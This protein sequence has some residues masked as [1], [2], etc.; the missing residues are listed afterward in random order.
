MESSEL[1]QLIRLLDNPSALSEKIR[2]LKSKEIDDESVE[3][4]IVMYDLYNGN[5]SAIKQELV[6]SKMIIT[7]PLKVKKLGY[8]KYAAILI[9]FIGIGSALFLTDDI[10]PKEE[11]HAQFIEPGLV[12]YM[13]ANNNTAWEDI[14]FDYKMKK[15]N[16][17]ISKINLSLKLYPK[18]DTL[19]YFAGVIAFEQKKYHKSSHFFTKV[20]LL[21]TVFKDRS[22]Y[23]LGKIA[24]NLGYSK[25]AIKIFTSLLNSN[26]IDIKNASFAHINEI[27]RHL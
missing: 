11:L 17:A 18:N 13:S 24:Y 21:K 8:L 5:I 15:Y 10:Q 25:K 12:N 1:N 19:N 16:Q 6:K 2:E 23:Y 4:F 3:G 20:A 14:M 26:D 27:K 9:L 7:Q 22:N